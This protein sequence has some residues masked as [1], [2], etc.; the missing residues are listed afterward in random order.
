[1]GARVTCVGDPVEHSEGVK[2]GIEDHYASHPDLVVVDLSYA[3]GR[4][5]RV[6][7]ARR[8]IAN[9]RSQE[10]SGRSEAR[11]ISGEIEDVTEEVQQVLRALGQ[12]VVALQER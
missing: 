5:Y 10:L 9:A 6:T 11:T 2:K 1:M 7:L 4:G 12:S 8:V 3:S